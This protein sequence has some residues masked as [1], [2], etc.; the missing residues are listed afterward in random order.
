MHICCLLFGLFAWFQLSRSIRH[1]LIRYPVYPVGS[2]RVPILPPGTKLVIIRGD[3]AANICRDL[4]ICMSVKVSMCL[5][6]CSSN[7][8]QSQGGLWPEGLSWFGDFE[9]NVLALFGGVKVQES[10]QK[11]TL[12]P[13]VA[14]SGWMDWAGRGRMEGEWW[15]VANISCFRFSNFGRKMAGITT[16]S[17]YILIR[18]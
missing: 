2:K 16:Q 15:W 1:E 14:M 10:T 8:G 7:E 4:K 3:T 9:V 12:V 17:V 18:N 11:W 6:T 13:S 5:K